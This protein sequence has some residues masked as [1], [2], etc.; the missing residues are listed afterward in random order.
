MDLCLESIRHSK[1]SFS[2][3]Q[4]VVQIYSWKL[5]Q[6][7]NLTVDCLLPVFSGSYLKNLISIL[8]WQR[9]T[10]ILVRISPCMFKGV[11]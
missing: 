5:T 3:L 10:L 1:I 8:F 2:S 9:F 4:W 6:V 7:Q 11:L